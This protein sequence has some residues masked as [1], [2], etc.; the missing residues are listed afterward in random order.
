M[1]HSVGGSLTILVPQMDSP[2]RA[3]AALSG[4]ARLLD[5][6][7]HFNR[8][9]PFDKRDPLERSIRNPM[10]YADQVKIP[11]YLYSESANPPVAAVN[12]DFCA[13]VAKTSPCKHLAIKGDHGSMIGPSIESAIAAFNGIK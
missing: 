2:F 10:L 9:E 13:T 11:L 5:W 6:I 8:L 3:G 1:G 4:Y 7:D 12:A